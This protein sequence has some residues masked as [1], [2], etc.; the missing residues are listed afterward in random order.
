MTNMLS[1]L[2]A[3]RAP[4]GDTVSSFCSKLFQKLG[5]KDGKVHRESLKEALASDTS[6]Q[7]AFAAL[8][9]MQKRLRSSTLIQAGKQVM[10]GDAAWLTGTCI[11][12]GIQLAV[13][14]REECRGKWELGHAPPAAFRD[15]SSWNLSTGNPVEGTPQ[16]HPPPKGKPATPAH[17]E[18]FFTDYAPMIFDDLMRT[19]GTRGY[20]ESLGIDQLVSSL[21]VGAM[22]SLLEVTASGR[23]GAF[24]FASHDGRF[25]IKTIPVEE[26]DALMEIL[27]GY[28]QHMTS[29]PE[30]LITRYCGLHSLRYAGVKIHF[31]VMENAIQPPLGFKA[32]EQYDLKG[33]RTGRSVGHWFRREGVAMKDLDLKRPIVIDPDIQPVLLRQLEADTQFL[34]EAN[35]NDYSFL[36]GVHSASKAIAP[37]PGYP[38]T[39]VQILRRWHGG[40]PSADHKEVFFAGIIDILT[41]FG[42]RKKAEH[43]SKSVIMCLRGSNPDEVSCVPPARYQQRFMDFMTSRLCTGP[44]LRGLPIPDT[45]SVDVFAEPPDDFPEIPAG[46]GASGNAPIAMSIASEAVSVPDE[47]P[48]D[49]PVVGTEPSRQNSRPRPLIQSLR[50]NFPGFRKSPQRQTA[51]GTIDDALVS[52]ARGF[53]KTG[54]VDVDDVGALVSAARGFLAPQPATL[55]P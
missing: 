11:L 28:Y 54:K 2:N 48:A 37:P 35:L 38:D 41:H 6:F 52:A 20:L 18:V 29:H 46:T 10:F 32:S 23:S 3:F 4:E 15:K 36:I 5:P 25:Y 40:F 31:I 42:L 12:S 49:V 33:S 39:R 13:Q 7:E 24:F 22:T 51:V 45:S 27:P 50:K 44:R 43:A 19:A 21:L 55:A 9:V 14:H 26:A 16:T 8:A 53:D 1:Q 17:C 30:S 34:R 47:S